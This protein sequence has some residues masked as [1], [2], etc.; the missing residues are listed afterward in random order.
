[1]YDGVFVGAT[2]SREMMVVMAGSMLLV[3]LPT[4]FGLSEYGN[5]AL[6]LAFLLFM[7]AR[8]IGMHFW[9]RRLVKQDAFFV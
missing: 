9:F 4:W 6:W 1:M 3:F 7:G 8:G 5:H 2:R